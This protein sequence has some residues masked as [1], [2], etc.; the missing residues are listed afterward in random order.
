[1]IRRVI[2]LCGLFLL[3]ASGASARLLDPQAARRLLLTD[4]L[5]IG[6]D[7]YAEGDTCSRFPRPERKLHLTPRA[8]RDPWDDIY[9]RTRT[10]VYTVQPH[11]TL[12]EVARRHAATVE[13]LKALNRIK[14][15]PLKAGRKLL[16]PD[17]P[18]TIEINKALNRLY[19]KSG[20]VL[21]SEYHVST[22]K[23]GAQTPAGIFFIQTRYPYPTWFHKG[24]VVAAGS[25]DNYLGSRWLGFDKPQ[26]G[27]HGT[28]FPELIGRSVSGGCIRMRNED[29]EELYELIPVG[30]MVIITEI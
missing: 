16:V 28:I 21:V 5:A 15:G 25:P 19:L 2:I 12:K 13:F 1:M 22:G 18:F 17:Q 9:A 27:I 20:D 7:R 8:R 4:L 10:H 11:D 3:L 30:T 26:Y 24:V 6:H 29:V 23:R 14:G